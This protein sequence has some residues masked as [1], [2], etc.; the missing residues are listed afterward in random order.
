MFL[1]RQSEL[2]S[3]TLRTVSK[4]E[5]AK[6][7]QLLIRAGFIYKNSAGVYTYLPLGFRVIEKLSNII[8]EEMA[9]IGGTE[10]FMPALVDRRYLEK[11]DRF[12]LPV[13]FDVF[14]KGE[15]RASFSLGWTHE[16]VVTEIVS[17]YVS[18]YK[19]LPFS[20]YQIQ[21]KFRNEARAKSGLLRGVEFLMKDLYSFHTSEKDLLSYYD[22]VRIAYLKVFKRCGLDALYTVAAGGDFTASNTHEFQVISDVGEDTIFYCSRCK[23]AENQEIS[24]LKDGAKCP[25][26]SEKISKANA[27]EVGN[28]FPLGSK[29]ADVFGLSFQDEKG[30]KKSV[31]MGSYGIGISRL[32]AS[33][34]EVHYD[35]YGI[36]W[37]KEVA[38]FSMHLVYLAS[39]NK[40]VK[41]ESDKIYD[42]LQRHGMD[43]LYDDREETRAGEKFADSDL[44]GMPLRIVVSEKTLGRGVEVKERNKKAGRLIKIES[45]Y[46][47]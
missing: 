27:I 5:T 33:V 28:I 7:A 37:P 42:L 20:V 22:R 21:T 6:N 9:A 40:K 18:S 11:T 23:Y 24:K 36:V 1:M 44:L 32:M 34:V 4:E 26:C 41:K 47:K 3:K 30:N 15:K 25:K 31:I 13:G 19:D 43:V 16:E 29:Y 10:L 45:L 8:R 17:K 46:A 38:P 35:K 39:G 12:K 2:F 14:G